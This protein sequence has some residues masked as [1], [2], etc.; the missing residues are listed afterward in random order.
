MTDAVFQLVVAVLYVVGNPPSGVDPI[1]Y[2]TILAS[3]ASVL[4]GLF[5]RLVLCCVVGVDAD[6]DL[7][8]GDGGGESNAAEM[9]NLNPSFGDG[10]GI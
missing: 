5:L 8:S 10:T 9:D 1:V 2:L 4:T 7:E 3:A 6:A